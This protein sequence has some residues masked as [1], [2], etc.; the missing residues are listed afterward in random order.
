MRVLAVQPGPGF[1]VSDV[2]AGY[3]KALRGLGCQVV[4][5][6]L[7]DR[8]A[9]YELAHLPDHEGGYRKAFPLEAAVSLAVKGVEAAAYEVWPD[10]VL[11]TSGFFLQPAHYQLMR[12]RGHKVVLLCTEQPYELERELRLAPLVDLVLLNDPTH[13]EHFVEQNTE[14]YY[15]PHAY[16]PEVHYP[17]PGQAELASDFALVGT[18]YPSRIEFLERVDWDGVDAALAGNWQALE[19]SSRLRRFVAHDLAECCPNELAAELYRATKASAN[20][21]RREA[22]R[23]DL[24]DGWATGPREVELA[25]CGVPFLREHRGE[26]DELFPHHPVFE[27]PEEFGEQLRWLL[28]NDDVRAKLGQQGREAIAERTFTNHAKRLLRL[29][30]KE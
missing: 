26:G 5:F 15:M 2:H 4:D 8:L 7:S 6:N 24:A 30:D 11:V 12:R 20:L 23:P 22:Q 27:T 10:V 14:T 29:L 17:G 18:G 9:L 19:E 25:A 28:A 1:S 21:Y 16:D 13:I 3:V